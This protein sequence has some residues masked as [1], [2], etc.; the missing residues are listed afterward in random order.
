[1]KQ[2][3]IYYNTEYRK[4]IKALSK[5]NIFIKDRLGKKDVIQEPRLKKKRE[6]VGPLIYKNL[7]KFYKLIQQIYN[8]IIYKI[9]YDLKLN[10][11]FFYLNKFLIKKFYMFF[12][13]Q[14]ILEYF[15]NG[16][17]YFLLIIN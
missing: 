11:K 15:F 3:K 14:L 7:S 1:M 4:K 16:V 17:I 9:N 12:K 2:E 5:F 13:N 10:L 8:R 6:L